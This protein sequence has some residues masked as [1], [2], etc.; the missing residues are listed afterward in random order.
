MD[1]QREICIGYILE[2]HFDMYFWIKDILKFSKH[3][4][5]AFYK[6]K[7]DDIFSRFFSLDHPL[8]Y[9]ESPLNATSN[10]KRIETN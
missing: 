7:V 1:M 10:S 5:A 8:I 9:K 6:R 3:F 4:E 2:E